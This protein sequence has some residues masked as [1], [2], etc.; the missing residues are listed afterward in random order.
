MSRGALLTP[1]L[2][3]EVKRLVQQE[4]R[5]TVSRPAPQ[6][7]RRHPGGSGRGSVLRRGITTSG[8]TAPAA[9]DEAGSVMVQL[10]V[11]D[12]DNEGKWLD[13]TDSDGVALDP[14]Q[15]DVWADFSD[16][17]TGVRVAVEKDTSGAWL[18]LTYDCEEEASTAITTPTG[19][20]AATQEQT[21]AGLLSSVAVTPATL[22][23]YG[24]LTRATQEQ[25][26]AGTDSSLLVTPLTLANYSGLGGGGGG[27]VELAEV[28]VAGPGAVTGLQKV[29]LTN[30]TDTDSITWDV[31]TN[32]R[33]TVS[34]DGIYSLF[35]AVN[36]YSTTQRFQAVLKV[37]VNGTALGPEFG[38]AYIRNS[39]LAYDFG[40]L[41]LGW[42][43]TLSASDY[44]EVYV[45]QRTGSS[46]GTSGTNT[47][48]VQSGSPIRSQIKLMRNA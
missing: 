9:E 30:K 22:A 18:L 4:A 39:G 20:D 23:S 19:L 36:V 37:Y 41:V 42:P 1:E 10:Q 45:D 2:A 13:E 32:H 11:P 38:F 28:D 29:T 3:R 5:R 46:W 35:A 6:R 27:S 15:V 40:C 26:D 34:A 17:A 33:G 24:G 16:S 47:Y 31:T 12:P 14:V 21:D 43:L 44:V 8:V 48:S 25:V 7:M